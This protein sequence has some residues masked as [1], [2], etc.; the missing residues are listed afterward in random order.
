MNAKS[1]TLEMDELLVE[2]A[3]S[4]AEKLK[5]D[6]NSLEYNVSLLLLSDK[7]VNVS[8]FMINLF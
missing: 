7:F 1:W 8:R 2:F 3:E 6:P 5:V 4:L